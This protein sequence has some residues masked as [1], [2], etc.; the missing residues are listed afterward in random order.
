M[1]RKEIT[2]H[3]LWDLGRI[4]IINFVLPFG[5]NIFEFHKRIFEFHKSIMI[6]FLYILLSVW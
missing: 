5:K 6:Y 2:N 4:C 1:R 3:K